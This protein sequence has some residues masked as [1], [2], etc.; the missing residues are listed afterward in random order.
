MRNQLLRD[1]DWASMAHSLELRVPFVD[2]PTLGRIAP[3]THRLG[4]RAGKLA[5]ANAPSAPLPA[6]VM[7]RGR[8][9]FTVPV[10]RWIGAGQTISSG[11]ASRQWSG[12]VSA[13]FTG[14]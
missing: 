6:E 12:R 1:A 14:A 7:N 9:G 4:D 3:I 10:G 5:L 2:W 8:T 13:A 11:L